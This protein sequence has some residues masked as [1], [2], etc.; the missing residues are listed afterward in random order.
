MRQ[1]IFIAHQLQHDTGKRLF[2]GLVLGTAGLLCV[3]LLLLWLV[4]TMGFSQIHPW[5]PAL[6]AFFTGACILVILTIAIGLTLCAWFGQRGHA[7]PGARRLWQAA[8][9]ILLPLMEGAG[10]L[11]GFPADRIRRSFIKVNNEIILSS[12]LS[13]TPDK[14]MLLLPHCLQSSRCEHRLTY[15]V[16]NCRRCGACPVGPLLDLR[17]RWGIKLAIAVG[18]SVARRIVVQEKPR[19]IIAVACERDLSSGIQDTAP[20]PVYGIINT[21]PCGP[22]LDTQVSLAHVE[23]ALAFFIPK[24]NHPAPVPPKKD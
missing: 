1:P 21:R 15:H 19:L 20:L 8:A 18:G 13:C 22:C 6:T 11:L 10:R 3:L 17:D 4:P 5:L 7:I 2:I 9:R 16:D 23:Q 12:A 24:E 14:T